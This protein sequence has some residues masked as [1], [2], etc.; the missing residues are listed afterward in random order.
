ME[1]NRTQ[2]R[3]GGDNVH[4]NSNRHKK[5]GIYHHGWL[6]IGDSSKIDDEAADSDVYLLP[7][8][9]KVS[10]V[11]DRGREDNTIVMVL[12]DYDSCDPI[13]P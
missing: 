5:L 10:V 8:G 2:R 3:T 4:S 6:L 7:E 9:K 12:P 1:S 13:D 11:L